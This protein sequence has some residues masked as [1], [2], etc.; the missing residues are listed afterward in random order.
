MKIFRN[1]IVVILLAMVLVAGSVVFSAYRGMKKNLRELEDSFFTAQNKGPMYYVDQII[2]AA[3]SV[4]AVADH[5]DSLD[6][7]PIRDARSAM[8]Q[9]ENGRDLSDLYGA[10]VELADAVSGLQTAATGVELSAQDKSTLTDGI[11]TIAGARRELDECGYNERALALIEEN[12]RRF[13]GS[14]LTRLLN[15]DEPELFALEGN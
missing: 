10:S 5:Y 1:R 6:A 4:A 9:A 2:S 14:L 13:P 12:Y 8:V 15:I 7:K 11:N 3:A